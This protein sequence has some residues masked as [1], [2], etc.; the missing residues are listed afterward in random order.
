MTATPLI[1]LAIWYTIARSNANLIPRDILTYY[2]LVILIRLITSSWRGY[3]L[4][5]Q[6]LNGTIVKY[7]IR[8]PAIYWDFLV[9]NLTNKIF[10]LIFILPILVIAFIIFPDAVSPIIFSLTNLG[11]FLLSLLLA[12]I[13]TFTFDLSLGL[14]AFWLEDA[15][16]LMSYRFLLTQVASGVLI[17]FAMMPDWL[18]TA[19][20]FLPFRYIISAPAEILLGQVV[21]PAALQ[22]IFY[23]VIWAIGFIIIMRVL[24]V[25]GLRRYAIPGQ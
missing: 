5:Q 24:F 10:Q 6:I 11:P 15:Q 22:L 9:N 14:L 25:R 17:P 21:G 2:I 4:I 8:P 7:L 13:I 1:S 19:F 16:E 12:F 20:S 18:Y 3:Y 23:Q